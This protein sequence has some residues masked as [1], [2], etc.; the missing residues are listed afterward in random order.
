MMRLH[1]DVRAKSWGR[2]LLEVAGA[3][4]LIGGL[5]VVV[6]ATTPSASALPTPVAAYDSIQFGNGTVPGSPLPDHTHSDGV[7]AYS[8]S[9]MGQGV[10]LAA[11]T[12]RTLGDTQVTMVSWGCESYPGGVC[13]STPGDTYDGFP[14]TFNI[15][16]ANNDG[17]VGPLIAT[18]TQ[19][20]DIP[21]N[22]SGTAACGY[23]GWQTTIATYDTPAGTCENGLTDN[24]TFDGADFTPPNPVLPNNVIY[25]IAYNTSTNGYSPYGSS[26]PCNTADNGGDGCF[27]DSLNIGN[28]PTGYMSNDNPDEVSVGQNT[29]AGVEYINGNSGYS[30]CDDGSSGTGTFREDTPGD[31]CWEGNTG[32]TPAPATDGFSA[33]NEGHEQDTTPA[34]EIDTIPSNPSAFTTTLSTPGSITLGQ[35]ETDTAMV[36][37][38]DGVAPG[39][40]VN[41][42]LCGLPGGAG[43]PLSGDTYC[44]PTGPPEPQGSNAQVVSTSGGTSTYASSSSVT[45]TSTGTYCWSAFFNSS[46]GTVDPNYNSEGENISA[47]TEDNSECFTVTK[48]PSTTVSSPASANIMLGSV[49]S[50]NV[51]VTGNAAGGS[52]TGSVEFYECG[53]T[54]NVAACTTTGPSNQVGP[55]ESVTTGGGDA[56]TT[57]SASFTPTSTGY[58]CFAA[59]YSGDGNYSTSS[60]TTTDECV[61]VARALSGT[62]STPANTTIA[63]GQADNDLATVIGVSAGGSPTGTVSFY[64]CGPTVNPAACT[65]GTQV[66]GA[67]TVSPGASPLSTATSGPF[68]P[69]STGYWCFAAVYSGD[70]NYTTSSDTTPDECVD[71]TTAGASSTTQPTSPSISLGGSN[72][73]GAVLHGNATGGSPTGMVTFYECAGPTACTPGATSIGSVGLTAGANNT[74][75]AT[76]PPFTPTAPGSWCFAVSYPGDS[77]YAAEF[78]S[79]SS[80][81][82][83]VSKAS[84]TTTSA[85]TATTITLGQADTDKAMVTGSAAGGDPTQTVSFYQCGETATPTPCTST[86]NQIG[87][88]VTVT[89]GAGDTATA[90]SASFTPTSVGYWCFAAVYSGDSNYLTSSDTTVDECVDVTAASTTIRT[91]PTETTIMLGQSDTDAVAVTGNATGGSPTGTV[92]FYVCTAQAAP[93]ACSSETTQVGSTMTLSPGANSTATATSGSFTPTSV[94][95]WCFA[96]VYSPTGTSYLG[97]SDSTTDECVDVTAASTTTTTTP[98]HTTLVLGGSDTD[99][100]AVTGNATGGSP[101]GTVTFYECGPTVAAASCISQTHQVGSAVSVTAGAGNA[102]T[103]SSS[104]FTPTSTGYWCFAGVY[105]GSTSYLTSSDTTTDECVHVTPATSTTF[106]TPTSSSLALGGSDTDMATVD[107]NAA[108][109]SPTGTVSFYVCGPNASSC[110]SRANQIGGP[111]TVTAGA[112]DSSMATSPSFAPTAAGTWCFAAVYSGDTN[113]T[114]SSDSVDGCITVNR[115]TTSTTTTPTNATITLGQADTDLAMVTGNAAGGSPTGTVSFYECGPT[116]TATPCTSTSNPVGGAVSLTAGANNTATA[117]SASFTPTASGYWCFTA[118]Y[119]GDGNYLTSMDTTTDECVNV[120]TS[121][122]TIT[123]SSPTTAT[124]VLGGNDSDMATVKGNATGGSPTGTVSFYACGPTAAPTACSSTADQVGSAVSL[125]TG[126]N[127]SSTAISPT[128][129]P[130]GGGYWCF[131]ADYSGSSSYFTSSDASTDECFDVTPVSSVMTT[132]PSFPS[133]LLGA[134]DTDTVAVTGNAA[135]GSPTGTVTFYACG[136]TPSPAPCT[137]TANP[138]GSPVHVAPGANDASSGTSSAFM[139]TSPGY[140]CFA[141]VYSGSLDYQGSSDTTTDECFHVTAGVSFTSTAPSS[142]T[143][144]SGQ[145]DT[146]TATVT[147]NSAGGSPTGDVSFYECGPTTSPTDCTST[148]DPVGGPV[149]LVAGA[150]DTATAPS[151]PFTPSGPGYWCF[152]GHYAATTDYL[153]STDESLDECFDVVSQPTTL[154]ILTSSLPAGTKG[155]PYSTTLNAAGGLTPY[156]WSVS[157]LPHGLHLDKATGVISGTPTQLGEFV[158]KI[159]VKDSTSPRPEKAHVSLTLTINS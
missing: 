90:T 3:G 72:T 15:Y 4:T 154:T 79:G 34:V 66:G 88:A 23:N 132:A 43:S 156:I 130:S 70:S 99:A 44:N 20:F 115:S 47:G 104:A 27:Y 110:T 16:S 56:S 36:T 142:T 149:A 123:S 92:K 61:H 124:V 6:V 137:S 151:V 45:P 102:S 5:L 128:F 67:V 10:T 57:S 33:G 93:V 32:T 119:S 95:Y 8:F 40:N 46:D 105:S 97:S 1:A 31:T 37:G 112:S 39:G 52:P 29:I 21:Y 7:Q 108:G 75:T 51:A 22:P 38:V 64:E 30:Y 106:E 121:A 141:G 41:Y 118:D 50:D 100:E 35:S 136:E 140:W 143:I 131:A 83:I 134:S 58:W 122:D 135:G 127:N 129:T 158:V 155:T 81:C 60:D 17:S 111:V 68:T 148:A 71:V 87:S 25:G 28:S 153:A 107:G 117:T 55:A 12:P 157:K 42:Y 114:T 91:T 65:T 14:I 147:G 76:S 53:P 150:N 26:N 19:D 54:A 18:D 116:G 101:G 62:S 94:G 146:D 120:V 144:V 89:P 78:E 82:F 98:T 77:H 80:E 86:A 63:L 74:A 59:V 9:E 145:S 125:T 48:N 24:I 113:Y 109:G 133:I 138:V 13:T 152:A 11:G 126:A 49:M 2:R 139:P 159:R 103:A 85:P 73:D 69:S 84:T 96:G